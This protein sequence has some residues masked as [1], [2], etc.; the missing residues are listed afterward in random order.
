MSTTT[1]TVITVT[2]EVDHEFWAMRYAAVDIFGEG[3]S[4]PA[5]GTV[6][7]S[8]TFV[9]ASSG[10]KDGWTEADQHDEK[11]KKFSQHVFRAEFP[12]EVVVTRFNTDDGSIK[13]Y[14]MRNSYDC[15][16]HR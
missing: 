8:Q 7:G 10:S 14:I 12:G 16:L 2:S 4:Q 9:I 5:K 6:N 13:A 3:V 15:D 1:H 11:I